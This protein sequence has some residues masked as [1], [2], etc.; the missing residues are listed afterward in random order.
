M[1]VVNN[2]N[3]ASVI[4]FLFQQ[5]V[6]GCHDYKA[7]NRIK[8]DPEQQCKDLLVLLHTSEH[9]EAFIHLYAAIKEESQL[10]W[11]VD[12]IDQ[13]TDQPL[14]SLLQQQQ[15]QQQK[16]H[17][18]ISEPTGCLCFKEGNVHYDYEQIILAS[19]PFCLTQ[20]NVPLAKSTSASSE[21][22]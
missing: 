20:T 11:L 1:T 18:Y 6:L 7:L 3:P 19:M 13:F 5:H 16:Q 9:P 12:R 2:V 15:Q 4:D 10:H 14:T 21:A 17:Q 22:K 8:D